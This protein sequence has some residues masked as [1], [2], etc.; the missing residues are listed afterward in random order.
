[1]NDA[2]ILQSFHPY[3]K[4]NEKKVIEALNELKNIEFAFK[5]NQ[6]TYHALS[7]YFIDI[8][9]ERS[10]S[11]P[12]NYFEMPGVNLLMQSFIAKLRLQSKQRY[13]P[14]MQLLNR[15]PEKVVYRLLKIA[16]GT[17][18]RSL[19]GLLNKSPNHRIALNVLNHHPIVFVNM[20]LAN[21]PVKFSLLQAV[22]NPIGLKLLAKKLP[23]SDFLAEF[24]AP[25]HVKIPPIVTTTKGD[26]F[27]ADID[28]VKLRLFTIVAE[29]LVRAATLNGELDYLCIE[30]PPELKCLLQDT[31]ISLATMNPMPR[32]LIPYIAG[33]S[34]R[35][36]IAVLGRVRDP[37]ALV[38]IFKILEYD[39]PHLMD[40]IATMASKTPSVWPALSQSIRSLP[41]LNMAIRFYFPYMMQVDQD[42][43]INLLSDI[44]M[45]DSVAIDMINRLKPLLPKSFNA[46][47]NCSKCGTIAFRVAAGISM[48]EESMWKQFTYYYRGN[49]EYLPGF[50]DV[51]TDLIFSGNFSKALKLLDSL[52][53]IYAAGNE[54]ITFAI[55]DFIYAKYAQYSFNEINVQTLFVK[56]FARVHKFSAVI[57]P[58]LSKMP[59]LSSKCLNLLIR[60]LWVSVKDEDSNLIKF[61]L[62]LLAKRYRTPKEPRPW[63]D[64]ILSM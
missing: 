22:T 34:I 33:I 1:M 50:L 24:N 64:E 62:K 53:T 14:E 38:Q 63:T 54:R 23:T 9:E 11:L 20:I 46:I 21:M 60:Y 40:K 25:G 61:R 55:F 59:E 13:G 56:V 29:P 52:S 44:K 6:D 42:G 16:P 18:L 3:S 15:L 28:D 32:C 31:I 51:C 4:N 26:A 19:F 39:A 5:M 41:A 10:R 30:S 8:S 35:F 58:I 48:A 2:Q 17:I 43:C 36:S 12:K 47:L 49:E 45:T 7:T 57:L 27:Y 37:Y